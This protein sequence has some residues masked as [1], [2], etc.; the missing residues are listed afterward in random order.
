MKEIWEQF[1]QAM[2]MATNHV[3]LIDP[4]IKTRIHEEFFAP[5]KR[6]NKD[7]ASLQ[8]SKRQGMNNTQWKAGYDAF[9]LT[10]RQFQVI[11]NRNMLKLHF[12]I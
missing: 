1:N 7:V 5:S 4:A 12:L 3:E 6:A 11:M 10:M 2:I 9:I 8:S